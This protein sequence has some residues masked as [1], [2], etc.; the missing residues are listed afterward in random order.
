MNLIKNALDAMQS[1]GTLKLTVTSDDSYVIAEV[2]DTGV[3][4]A[5]ENMSRLFQ[6]GFTTKTKG[7]GIGL[8][9]IKKIIEQHKGDI[10][11]S[12]VLGKGT[13]F[14]LK[15]PLNIAEAK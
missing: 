3:G 14:K 12:S 1:G 15:L 13:V 8:Y 11:V 10:E 5:P 9:S 6:L 4:I 2:G 7:Y